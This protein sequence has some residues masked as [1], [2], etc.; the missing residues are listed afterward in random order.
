MTKFNR[1][2]TVTL[3]WGLLFASTSERF[4]QL[5][6]HQHTGRCHPCYLAGRGIVT[7]ILDEHSVL[8]AFDDGPTVSVTTGQLERSV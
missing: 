1:N 4:E 5:R 8:V 6:R 2:D 7:E 3:K